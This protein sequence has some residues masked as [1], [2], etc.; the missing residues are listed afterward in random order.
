[1][2]M[3]VQTAVAAACWLALASATTA[4]TGTPEYDPLGEFDQLPKQVRVQVE[5]I[6][7]SHEA[8]TELMFGP[9]AGTND[10][11]LRA[12]L[13]ELIK[14]KQASIMET[15]MCV[16][17]NAE[18]GKT[19]S[20]EEVIYATEYEPATCPTTVDAGAAKD[21]PARPVPELATGPTPSAWDTRNTGSTFE[22]EPCILEG[23]KFVALKILPELVYHV[24]NQIW[25]EWK[26]VHGSAPIQM[27]TFYTVR[28]DCSLTVVPGQPSLAG[29]LSPKDDK[30]HTNFTRKLMVFVKADVLTVGR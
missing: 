21:A 27:P 2:K 19:E 30:G 3:P 6:E 24:G 5:F 23:G 4:Q 11:D 16:A 10:S 8:Y 12:K 1:M 14:Q 29:A 15:M 7:V 28:L 17:K 18:K 22:V 20:I 25:T 13:A 26:D 9:R